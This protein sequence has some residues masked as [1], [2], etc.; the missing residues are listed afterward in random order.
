MPDWDEIDFNQVARLSALLGMVGVVF[1]CSAA[2]LGRVWWVFELVTHFMLPLAILGSIVLGLLAWQRLWKLAGVAALLWLWILVQVIPYLVNTGGEDAQ[3]TQT[4]RFVAL[5]LLRDNRETDAVL[6]FINAEQ[7]DVLL[8]QEV[9]PRWERQL[10]EPLARE[11]PHRVMQ[12]RNHAFGIWLLSKHP[13]DQVQVLP[14][15]DSDVPYITADIDLGGET[16]HLVGVHPLPP[17]G[18]SKARERNQR[19]AA[20]GEVISYQPGA[21]MVLGDLNATPW[22]PYFRK[23]RRD[24][25]L[26][27][28]GRWKGWSPTWDPGISWL[29]LPI[30]HCLVS[31][32]VGV[33][34]RRVGPAVG[35]DHRG[36]SVDVF[37]R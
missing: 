7:A 35:S 12:V 17:T 2:L 27:D 24:G 37:F 16:I 6:D 28:S 26:R 9:T 10:R 23:L 13:L 22:S 18:Q 36:L 14:T 20:A 34:E 8:L 5:N 4:Y 11:Y 25:G 30:D 33:A 32:E 29:R 31:E 3:G 15:P 19:L 1:A 21:R